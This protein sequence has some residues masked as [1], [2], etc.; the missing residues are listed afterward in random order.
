MK[1][2]SQIHVIVEDKK[3]VLVKKQQLDIIEYVCIF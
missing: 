2:F 3:V 1:Q